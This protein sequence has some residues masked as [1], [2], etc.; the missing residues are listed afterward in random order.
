MDLVTLIL[1][2]IM[3]AVKVVIYDRDTDIIIIIHHPEENCGFL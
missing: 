1:S 3:S 2:V